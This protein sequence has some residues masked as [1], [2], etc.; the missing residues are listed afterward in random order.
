MNSCTH[1]DDKCPRR[2]RSQFRAVIGSVVVGG[3]CRLHAIYV[4]QSFTV[5]D[6]WRNC[7]ARGGT[8]A[9]P[10]QSRP[11]RSV[12]GRAQDTRKRHL[13]MPV[14]P[15]VLWRR[16][17]IYCWNSRKRWSIQTAAKRRRRTDV[18]GCSY[19]RCR[20]SWVMRTMRQRPGRLGYRA[21]TI[22]Q[23][24]FDSRNSPDLEM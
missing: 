4:N 2:K 6:S 19:R 16:H 5:D 21:A 23:P 7:Q 1:G 17:A 8:A 13:Q 20:G 11:S 15:I 22:P 12:I 10:T 18:S 3:A 14:T 24:A 9:D